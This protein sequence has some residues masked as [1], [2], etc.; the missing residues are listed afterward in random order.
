[1]ADAQK[2]YMPIVSRVRRFQRRFPQA[3]N[4]SLEAREECFYSLLSFLR[5]LR[6]MI[7]GI[8]SLQFKNRQGEIVAGLAWSRL[9]NEVECHFPFL[10]LER[11]H[12]AMEPG[13]DFAT[14]LEHFTQEQTERV[15]P[16]ATLRQ[17]FDAW[18]VSTTSPMGVLVPLIE[19]L[20][21]VM[22][23]EINRPFEIWYGERDTFPKEDLETAGEALKEIP[24]TE[25]LRAVLAKYVEAESGL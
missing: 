7:D 15:Q 4:G 20:T 21:I 19:I 12:R 9:R 6:F 1:L 10:E 17:A 11:V 16:F 3:T 8:G 18:L 24:D 23:V 22:T 14:F 5:Q 13:E 2:Y 25:E